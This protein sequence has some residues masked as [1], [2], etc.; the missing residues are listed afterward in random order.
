M[1]NQKILIL[2]LFLI[3][4]T[5]CRKENPDIISASGVLDSTQVRI[6]SRIGGKII[7]TYA[8]EGMKVRKGDILFET[9]C[10]ELKLQL[11]QTETNLLIAKNQYSLT[12]KGA[13]KED[14]EQVKYS[15]D[16]LETNLLIARNDYERAKRL[17]EANAISQKMLEDAQ[18]KVK[19]IEKQ[20]EASR[21]NYQ[22]IKN[23]SRAEEIE[24]ARLRVESSKI[25]T[26]ILK[27]RI[28]DC[29]VTSPLDGTITR[30]IF[31]EGELINPGIPVFLVT[32][33]SKIYLKIY[34]PEKDILKIKTGD[35]AAIKTDIGT[36]EIYGTVTYIS[37]EAEFTPKT[38]QTKDERTKLVFMVKLEIQNNDQILKPGLP[39]DAIFRITQK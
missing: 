10:T 24:A 14:I 32:D 34:L 31:S 1:I 27:E 33:T 3:F 11:M 4:F 5:E 29:N 20:I 18:F 26:D 22:K 17:F 28:S 13:R 39:A 30:K 38:I 6:S 12:V 19:I 16:I 25:A 36:K 35:R 23:I 7:K 15:T 37:E 21:Q 9:D 2:L 8:D